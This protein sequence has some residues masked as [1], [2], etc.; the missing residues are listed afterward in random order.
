MKTE[1]QLRI[2]REF[3]NVWCITKNMLVEMEV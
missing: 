3:E 2:Q 1:K